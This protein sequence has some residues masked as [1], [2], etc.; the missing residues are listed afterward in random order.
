MLLDCLFLAKNEEEEEEDEDE[1]TKEGYNPHGYLKR[2]KKKATTKRDER[3]VK[4]LKTLVV[5]PASLLHQW[6]GEIQSKFE[7]DC[8][9]IHVYH[10]ADRKKRCYNMDD[11]DIVFTTYEI[12][13][14]EISLV[15]KAG[16]D[17][18]SVSYLRVWEKQVD[19]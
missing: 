15:D 14:R 3:C 9:K 18:Q 8:F 11:N 10:E 1:L 12:V 6:Q 5:L 2:V 17:V 13:S 7:R 16:N 19:P 4:R